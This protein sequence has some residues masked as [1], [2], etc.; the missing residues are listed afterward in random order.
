MNLTIL[1]CEKHDIDICNMDEM[2]LLPGR[3]C[4]KNLHYYRVELFYD[5]IDLQH[6]KLE[7]PRL[8]QDDFSDIELE[9][10]DGQVEAYILDMLNMSCFLNLNGNGDLE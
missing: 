9:I 10:L 6:T 5:V 7:S 8:Y 2:F 1:F 4:R 3:L